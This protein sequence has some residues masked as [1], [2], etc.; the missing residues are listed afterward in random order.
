[1][2]RFKVVKGS[3]LL[4]AVAIIVL[5]A[6]IAFILIQEG[7]APS[8]SA[9]AGAQMQILQTNPTEEAKALSAFASSSRRLFSTVFSR[10]ASSQRSFIS[11]LDRA[12]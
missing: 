3:H 12:I 4:L 7:G 8:E 11:G 9:G 1:M 10:S 6:A 2:V 5:I